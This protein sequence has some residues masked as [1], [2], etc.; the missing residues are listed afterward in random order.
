MTGVY[1]RSYLEFDTIPLGNVAR[2]AGAA[3]SGH[4]RP[5]GVVRVDQVRCS[6]GCGRHGRDCAVLEPG[7]V[8]RAAGALPIPA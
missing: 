2:G 3:K 6:Q 7:I 5:V 1:C 4:Q 8:G